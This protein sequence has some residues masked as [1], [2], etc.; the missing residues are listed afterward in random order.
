ML[1]LR[2]ALKISSFVL[3]C[4]LLFGPYGPIIAITLIANDANYYLDRLV[5]CLRIIV[6]P[7]IL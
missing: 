3:I 7:L 1:P 5:E 4:C 2:V 6:S